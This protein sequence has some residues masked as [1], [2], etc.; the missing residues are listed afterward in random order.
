MKGTTMETATK[1]IGTM[2]TLNREGDVKVAWDRN[3][4]EQIAAAKATFDSLKG[5]GY[6]AFRVA[7]GGQQGE[8]LHNFDANA[9]HIILVPQLRGG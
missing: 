9:E 4:P 8:Q 6:A 2:S 5:K 7:S 3:S 1:N